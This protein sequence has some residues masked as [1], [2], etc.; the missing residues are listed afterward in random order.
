MTDLAVQAKPIVANTPQTFKF[1][2]YAVLT[3]PHGDKPV[4]LTT[5]VEPFLLIPSDTSIPKDIDPFFDGESPVTEWL[6]VDLRT[7]KAMVLTRDGK[8]VNDSFEML[9]N[10]PFTVYEDD[11]EPTF[12]PG[13]E[14][15]VGGKPRSI[16]GIYVEIDD[17]TAAS[18]DMKTREHLREFTQARLDQLKIPADASIHMLTN[19]VEVV[20]E[21]SQPLILS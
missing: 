3:F 13:M 19:P 8:T 7:N 18:L 20:P 14:L 21:S 17:S 12:T 15:S 16:T 2:A 4:I 9:L 11:G 6:L 1:L 5:D 10:A